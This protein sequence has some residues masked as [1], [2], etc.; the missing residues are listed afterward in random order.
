MQAEQLH[1]LVAEKDRII[2]DLR[3]DLAL[4]QRQADVRVQDVEAGLQASRNEVSTFPRS[5]K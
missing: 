2:D 5:H 4:A 1:S 3:A